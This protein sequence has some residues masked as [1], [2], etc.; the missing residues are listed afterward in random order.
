MLF[1]CVFWNEEWASI[2]RGGKQGEV[3]DLPSFMGRSLPSQG[4]FACE[5]CWARITKSEEERTGEKPD[6]K[7]LN[8]A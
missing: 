2:Y 4:W 5:Q 8:R 1:S 7:V 3:E 6:P